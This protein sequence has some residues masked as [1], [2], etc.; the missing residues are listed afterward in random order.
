MHSS[1]RFNEK[2]TYQL[3]IYTV[4]VYDKENN[5]VL[6]SMDEKGGLLFNKW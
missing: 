3:A 4:H 5:G 6:I 1:G 2:Q